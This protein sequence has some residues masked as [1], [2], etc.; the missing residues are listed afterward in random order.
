[1]RGKAVS[2][3]TRSQIVRLVKMGWTYSLI[4]SELGMHRSVV[5]G[6]AKRAGVHSEYHGGKVQ[7]DE[8]KRREAQEKNRF[9]EKFC[10]NGAPKFV[11]ST[12]EE[13]DVDD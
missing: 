12:W 2:E 5:H 3:E 10:L 11:N 6:I 13:E 7:S 9:F 4:G 1:M 8:V